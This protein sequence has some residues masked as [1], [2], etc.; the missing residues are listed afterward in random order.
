M[1][2]PQITITSAGFAAIVNAEHSGTAPVK[3]THVGLTAQHFDVAT[4]GATVPGEAKRLTTFGGQA[5][6]ADTLHLNVRDDTADAYTLRGFGLYLQDGTL[7]AVYSQPAPIMEK[8]SA[9][10]MLLATD[11]RFAKVNATSIEVGNIDFINPPAT[12]SRVGVVRLATDLEAEA[13]SDPTLAL[14]P[15]GLARFI[16]KRFGDGA[17][18]AFV[19]GLLGLA[20]A[21]LFRTELGLRGA[22]LRDEGH[23]NGLDADLLDGN[24]GDYYRDWRNLTG[25]PSQFTPAPHTQAWSAI[26][27]QPDTAL[28][29]PTWGEV[30][31]KPATYPPSAHSHAWTD[32]GGAPDTATRW[33][34]WSEVT[35][36]PATYAPS[37]HAH[38]E[39]FNKQTGDTITGIMSFSVPASANI[40]SAR[41]ISV[42]EFGSTGENRRLDICLAAGTGVSGREIVFR[43]ILNSKF[44][45]ETPLAEFNGS[46]TA[47]GNISAAYIA[48]TGGVAAATSVTAGGVMQAGSE[49]VSLS[50]GITSR[51]VGAGFSMVE[52]SDYGVTWSVYASAGS[53]NLWNS[54]YGNAL[55][56]TRNGNV[57]AAGELSATSLKTPGDLTAGGTAHFAQACVRA[58][59]GTATNAGYVALHTIDG[60]RR[61][62]IGWNDGANKI[63]YSSEN[64]FSGHSFVG[65][66]AASGGFD[67]GSSRKLKDIDGPMPYGLAEVRQIATLIGRYK[68]EFNSDGRVRLFFDAEQFLSLMPE[69]VDAEGVAFNG[70]LVPSIKIEQALPPVYKAVAEL[71]DLVDW[72]RDESSAVRAELAALKAGRCYDQRLSLT[73]R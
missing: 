51:G 4:V 54:V 23:S 25:V 22:A 57:A 70:E 56:V 72:L 21:A 1:P 34:N 62:Y 18:S 7:F 45:F 68:P 39:Y 66:V 52:R 6:A 73:R 5:V 2:V 13:G 65:T 55:S 28:R 24:H 38:A 9:A 59:A 42:G 14:T 67:F 50:N 47:G 71:A 60:V 46:L 48:S 16:N 31:S 58:T 12:T 27:G 63:Q 33:P 53:L 35:N 64:G 30:T 43:G 37:A 49:I 36:K 3:L 69:A 26:S 17:P 8:A 32:I 20:T 44:R 11:I 10:V 15:F 29:W 40:D 41:F 61:G 19:K